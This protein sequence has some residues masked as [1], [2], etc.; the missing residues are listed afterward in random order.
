MIRLFLLLAAL[1]GLIYIFNWMTSYDGQILLQVG[2]YEITTSIVFFI[3]ISISII[4][5]SI[6]TWVILSYLYSLPKKIQ[7]FNQEKKKQ[8]IQEAITRGLVYASSGNSIAADAEIKKIDRL[9]KDTKETKDI[10][11][12]VLK[13]QNASLK[14]DRNQLNKIFQTMGDVE[15]TKM[16][17]YRGLYTLSKNSKNT[18]KSI[19]ILKDAETYNSNEPWVMEEML[20]CYLMTKNW[21][22]AAD[23]IEKKYKNKLIQRKD[24]NI[25]KA[26]ILTAHAKSIEEDSPD[27]ALNF[28][29]EANKL[30]KKQIIAT[31]VS[32]KIFSEIGNISKAEK[33]IFDTWKLNPHEDLAYIFSHI[34]PGISPKK[35][36]ERIE[37]L[38]KKTKSNNIEGAVALSRAYIDAKSFEEARTVL[39]PYIN[40]ESSKRIYQL[41]AEIEITLSES[42]TKSAE[43]MRKAMNSKYDTNWYIDDFT[44]NVWL[45]C[46]PDTGEIKSFMWGDCLIKSI[47]INHQYLGH[48]ANN[49]LIPNDQKNSDIKI[50]DVE[51]DE[52][53]EVNI[54]EADKKQS[55]IKKINKKSVKKDESKDI[56]KTSAPDDPGIIS[57]DDINEL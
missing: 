17:S 55:E 28:A 6:L 36:I 26:I 1:L 21:I 27:E 57:E 39:E 12:L 10:M 46:I 42:R 43:W 13:A 49:K 48:F 11:T 41:L 4:T 32:A 29:L 50:D 22:G 45:P 37:V 34:V 31:L 8:K 40:E 52:I 44:S 3:I 14:K 35:R 56:G 18:Q 7:K 5:F 51:V 2:E 30:D 53:E 20:K 24:Y 23:I 33:I 9:I 16:L 15:E 54:I 38:I 25:Q 47:D 19:E